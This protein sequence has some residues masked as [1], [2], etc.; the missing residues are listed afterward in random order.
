MS[1]QDVYELPKTVEMLTALGSFFEKLALVPEAPAPVLLYSPYSTWSVLGESV[2]Q[3]CQPAA[4]IT[5]L[6]LV[7]WNTTR[8]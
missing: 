6:R 7:L 8:E 1:T 2:P 5:L 4:L 3:M